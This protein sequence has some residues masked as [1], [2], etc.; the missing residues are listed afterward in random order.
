MSQNLK[1]GTKKS[2]IV[3]GNTKFPIQ[4][5][6][7]VLQLKNFTW[8]R[9]W[10][11]RHCNRRCICC[12]GGRWRFSLA[13][14]FLIFRRTCLFVFLLC[15]PDDLTNCIANFGRFFADG[16]IS[17]LSFVFHSAV[18]KPNFDLPFRQIQRP[19]NFNSSRPT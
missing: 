18:L 3:I 16:A 6:P 15:S 5:D 13:R 11:L 17:A 4:P 9:H 1:N 2:K 12:C 10:S 19:G 8:C 14:I 7:I